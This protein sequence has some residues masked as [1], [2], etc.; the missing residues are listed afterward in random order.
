MRSVR[1][2]RPTPA[3]AIVLAHPII[4]RRPT[5]SDSVGTRPQFD[6]RFGRILIN[7]ES[8]SN[9]ISAAITVTIAIGIMSDFG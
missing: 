6:Q 1:A 2:R 4:V 7:L 5:D 8:E 9:A 3:V